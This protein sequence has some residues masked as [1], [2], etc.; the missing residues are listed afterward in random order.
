MR[1]IKLFT[2]ATTKTMSFKLLRHCTRPSSC[3]SS[4]IRKPASTNR[5]CISVPGKSFVSPPSLCSRRTFGTA[6]PQWQKFFDNIKKGS[7]LD[8]SN[9]LKNGFDV[10]YR[11]PEVKILF[12]FIRS[13][14]SPQFLEVL[15]D[16]FLILESSY[17]FDNGR[18]A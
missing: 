12:N 6:F 2:R 14:I 4:L 5:Y 10:N 15:N 11:E 3:F 1:R 18:N 7:T 9:D 17:A 16:I 13:N 8:I